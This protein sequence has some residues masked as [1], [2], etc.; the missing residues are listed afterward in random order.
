MA[1]L[2]VKEAPAPRQLPVAE[3]PAF[4]PRCYVPWQQM[5]VNAD[6][7]VSPCPYYQGFGNRL[8]HLG[9]VNEQTI[10][11]VWNGPGYQQLRAFMAS[12][13]G[14][15]GCH[16]CL[17][18][19]Q[20]LMGYP[21]APPYELRD[22]ALDAPARKNLALMERE[23]AAKKTVIEAKP[24]CISYTPSQ[25]CNYRCTF[26]YQDYDHSL[27]L[28]DVER[29]DRE[30]MELVPTL[31]QIVAGGGEPF[32]LPIW[33]KFVEEFR[34]ETNPVLI[35]STTT[36]ASLLTQRLVDKLQSQ[37]PA[38]SINV[39]I[40][41]TH[42]DLFEKV[43]LQSNWDKVYDNIVRCL[44]KRGPE[45]ANGKF[46]V[47]GSMT[48]TKTNIGD[49]TNMFRFMVKHRMPITYTPCNVLPLDDSIASLNDPVEELERMQAAFDEF[50][51]FR[52]TELAD[53]PA[54]S[55]A[56]G[57]DL[58]YFLVQVDAMRELIPWR[59]RDVEHFPL[60]LTLPPEHVQRVPR[61]WYRRLI[62]AIRRRLP[63]LPP[64]PAE[65]DRVG[66]ALAPGDAPKVVAFFPIEGGKVA[67]PAR[68]YAPLVAD[69]RFEVHLPVG[70]YLVAV[71][72]R[73]RGVTADTGL[74]RLHVHAAVGRG[75][76]VTW[77]P[78]WGV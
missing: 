52:Q 71:R 4:K 62:T 1:V 19:K 28:R 42:K 18:I 31:V 67:E 58:K 14:K 15:D 75:R 55:K 35:F 45:T 47:S 7:N 12:P 3:A 13:E 23:V 6:G 73:N 20:G 34:T 70:E 72:P 43:R 26:C 50:E 27:K 64:I 39:S 40:D 37:F 59:L 46:L 21:T 25:E 9:N 30:L 32:L 57:I 8:P 76:R 2:D 48:V 60:K 66:E 49:I 54:A 51:R 44:T 11:E 53:V 56:C 22:V 5:I 10:L 61:P 74:W 68:Y 78:R 77:F 29:T 36:N 16:G 63:L 38:V 17:A 65:P 33:R 24:A 41:A 69:G